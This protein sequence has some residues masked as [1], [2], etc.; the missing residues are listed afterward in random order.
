MSRSA[1]SLLSSALNRLWRRGWFSAWPSVQ[2][3]QSILYASFHLAPEDAGAAEIALQIAIENY[4]G[5]TKWSLI[6]HHENRFVLCP[7]VVATEGQ[8]M[9]NFGEAADVVRSKWPQLER[10]AASDLFKLV[11]YL[12]SQGERRE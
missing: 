8:A 2:D 7:E 11:E 3:G 12:E 1:A 6:R 5:S 10:Q 9:G 4:V